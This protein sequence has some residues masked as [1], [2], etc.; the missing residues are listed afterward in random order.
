MSL[1]STTFFLHRHVIARD[2]FACIFVIVYLLQSAN[3]SN[4]IDK[5]A[6]NILVNLHSSDPKIFEAAKEDVQNFGFTVRDLPAIYNAV[7]G[8][9]PDDGMEFDSARVYLFDVLEKVH[10]E[11]TIDFIN[12]LYP[13]LPEKGELRY[14]ALSVLSLIDLPESQ[15]VFLKILLEDQPQIQSYNIQRLIAII[16]RSLK[17]ES[18]YRGIFIP[19]IFNLLNNKTYKSELYIAMPALLEEGVIQPE[20]FDEFV[21]I[22]IN[23]TRIAFD[24]LSEDA[25]SKDDNQDLSLELEF[26][27]DILGYIN[28][29]QESFALLK[30]G[31]NHYVPS[32]RL[33]ATL[34][35]AKLGNPPDR[36]KFEELASHPELRT[37]LYS[38]LKKMNAS[39]LYPEKYMT[40]F[41]FA[42]ADLAQWLCYPTEFG[43][44]PQEIQL[45]QEREIE[46]NAGN[47]G[48]VYL[49]KYRYSD[50][51]FPDGKNDGWLVGISGMQPID[52]YKF[53]VTGSFIDED[54]TNTSLT[55]SHMNKLSDMTIDEHFDSFLS[56]D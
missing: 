37:Q 22:I 51:Y 36:D 1:S 38:Y 23:D 13:T 19:K 27:M 21:P 55:F 48:W 34:S 43:G 54:G 6:D 20:D 2:I 47:K 52:R 40:Q 30:T 45:I 18:K 14:H 10:D 26:L 53:T 8:K 7:K 42:E 15:Q 16:G 31:L 46:D 28:Q 41:Y 24:A 25:N 12:N 3:T 49:F 32:I 5:N 50:D 56:D 33:W 9:Y 29:S 39:N 44:P 35:L 17:T 4:C 11:T